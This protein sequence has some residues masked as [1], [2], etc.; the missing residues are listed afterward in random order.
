MTAPA[1]QMHAPT[2]FT[3]SPSACVS[4]TAPTATRMPPTVGIHETKIA[5][6][7]ATGYRP[8]VGPLFVSCL[9]RSPVKT[10]SLS[11]DLVPTA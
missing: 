7:R 6:F 2:S 4:R 9:R 8:P 11:V 10:R 3:V 1:A 5:C